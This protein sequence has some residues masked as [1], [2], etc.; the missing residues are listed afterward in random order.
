MAWSSRVAAFAAALLAGCATVKEPVTVHVA[1]PVPC[2]INAP[3]RP[4]ITADVDL[5]AMP[6]YRLVITI[7]RERLALIAYSAEL[8]AAA[9]A[10][11]AAH[12]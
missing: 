9:R 10:C 4:T 11:E 5:Q 2:E 6:D 7:A 1:V 12:D 3:T 8:A